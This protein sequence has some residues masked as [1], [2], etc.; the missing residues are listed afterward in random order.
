MECVTCKYKQIFYEFLFYKNIST[1]VPY[2]LL[3][4]PVHFKNK[5]S[6]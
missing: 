6:I 4:E 5:N 3:I 2:L 1:P